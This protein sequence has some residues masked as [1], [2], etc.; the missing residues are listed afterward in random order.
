VHD[1]L[2]HGAHR[3]DVLVQG[4]EIAIEVDRHAVF[5]QPKRPVM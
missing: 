1:L 5:F 2:D 3:H 4:F